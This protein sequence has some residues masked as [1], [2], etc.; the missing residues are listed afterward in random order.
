MNLREFTEAQVEIIYL[1]SEPT[2]WTNFIAIFEVFLSSS[3]DAL[4]LYTSPKK[5]ADASIARFKTVEYFDCFDVSPQKFNLSRFWIKLIHALKLMAFNLLFGLRFF[6]IDG[7]LSTRIA[8]TV[9]RAKAIQWISDL[10]GAPEGVRV[11]YLSK[12]F[13]ALIFSRMAASYLV[14]FNTEDM[15]DVDSVLRSVLRSSNLSFGALL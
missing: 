9:V 6:L 11:N 15:L 13:T 2:E 10:V 5:L 14:T 1:D 3:D 7:F 4:L 8:R 12:N